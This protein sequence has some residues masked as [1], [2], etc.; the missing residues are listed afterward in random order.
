M[1]LWGGVFLVVGLL[2]AASL[3]AMQS[4]RAAIAARGRAAYV[5]GLVAGS[6]L[7]AFWFVVLLAAARNS[8]LVSYS[9][10]L[11]PLLGAFAHAAS[12]RSL[13]WH[14]GEPRP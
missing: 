4:K 8:E 2:E 5:L 13:A 1:R 12:A 9:S 3:A 14:E 10:C 11:W 6:G 7:S